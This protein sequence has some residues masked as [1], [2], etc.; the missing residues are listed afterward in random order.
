MQEELLLSIDPATRSAI[1][2]ELGTM[3]AFYDRLSVVVARNSDNAAALSEVSASDGVATR[4]GEL[5]A[6]V[7]AVSGLIAA[8]S[9]IVIAWIRSRGYEVEE[10]IET[11]KGGTTIRT[12]RVRHGTSR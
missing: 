2:D 4:G 1:V 7:T 8:L 6:I 3:N 10:K 5:V 9:P 11:R 12:L